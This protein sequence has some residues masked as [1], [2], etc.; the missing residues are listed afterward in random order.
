M[1]AIHPG[2]FSFKTVKWNAKYDYDFII[3]WKILKT[4]FDKNGVKKHF[5]IDRLVKARP[6]DNLEFIQWMKAYFD[7]NYS[8]ETYNALERRKQQDLFYIHG[9]GAN[10]VQK[11]GI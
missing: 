7:S 1:D 5:E 11:M 8:G 4:A 3:N 2:T 6:L 9:S 10:P